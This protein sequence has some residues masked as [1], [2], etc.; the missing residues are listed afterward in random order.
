VKHAI[1]GCFLLFVGCNTYQFE[2]VT[3]CTFV[4]TTKTLSVN[5][6]P[7]KPEL[8]LLVDK[9]GSM[10]FTTSTDPMCSSC[11]SAP[12]NL[13]GCPT[14]WD[15][16][17][18]AMQVFLPATAQ[19]VHLGMVPF[20]IA[21]P[22]QATQQC[23]GAQPGDVANFG[24]PL[25]NSLDSDVAGMQASANAVQS[26]INSI[27]P[28]G[29]TPT[30]ASVTALL[31]YA[32]L[33][34]VMGHPKFML[35][36]TD[37]VP[38]CDS[39]LDPNSCTCTQGASPCDV[40]VGGTVMNLCLDDTGTASAIGQ[41]KSAGVTTIVVGF[42]NETL[43]GLGPATLQQMGAAGGFTRPC[44]VDADC[45]AGDTC[46]VNATDACGKPTTACARSYYQATDATSLANTLVAIAN[47]IQCVDVCFNKLENPPADDKHLA[48]E[49][50]GNAVPGPSSDTWT[51]DNS[52]GVVEFVGK[53][54]DQLKTSTRAISVGFKS[55][56]ELGGGCQ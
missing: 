43:G 7:G 53:T 44:A 35:L 45:G 33:T 55:V 9:S 1:V 27:T 38:N 25:D 26:R 12:C 50:D 13:A 30:G 19:D 22:S 34:Q 36:L 5:A 52:T 54:C 2:P 16:L 28:Y 29:G 32:P 11:I 56:Q 21:D 8:F 42:G 14:R 3:P 51:Y 41:L 4:T 48:V 46:S 18:Q 24:V 40:N 49:F 17:T 20:P 37:G 6:K 15:G 23:T 39:A 10:T 31:Q 47:H